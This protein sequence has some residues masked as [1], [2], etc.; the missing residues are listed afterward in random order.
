MPDRVCGECTACCKTHPIKAL[1]NP[2]GVWCE[3]CNIGQGCK[4]Y[5]KRPQE[6]KDFKCDW[7]LGFFTEEQRPDKIKIVVGDL[8]AP[9]FGPMMALYEVSQFGLNTPF[10]RD[11]TR[12]M[13]GKGHY[14][15]HLPLIGKNRIYL[16]PRRI[17]LL[18]EG[19]YF[20][21]NGRETEI[22]RYLPGL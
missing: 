22:V 19:I 5:K 7:L 10:A 9:G 20:K 3:H 4:I 14:I 21:I 6:C 16:P 17:S 2:A 8:T 1:G 13:I 15:C 11:L 18:G 12:L